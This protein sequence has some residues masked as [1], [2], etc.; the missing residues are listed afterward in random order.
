MNI[1]ENNNTTAMFLI[2]CNMISMYKISAYNN[3]VIPNNTIFNI[4][5]SN[6]IKITDTKLNKT[7]PKYF[8]VSVSFKSIL[9][10]DAPYMTIRKAFNNSISNISFVFIFYN[11]IEFM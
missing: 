7:T 2:S 4:I 3:N 6:A 10:P 9:C 11:L 1:D 8:C 5:L